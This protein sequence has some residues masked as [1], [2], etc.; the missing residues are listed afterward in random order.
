MHMRTI[1]VVSSAL[2][3]GLAAEVCAQSQ[4]SAP[5]PPTAPATSSTGTT[6]QFGLNLARIQRG[7]KKSAERQDFDGLNLRYYVNVYAPAPSI[8]LFTREDNLSSG[9]A[10]Y[11]GPTHNEMMQVMTPQEFRA[12]AADFTG[13]ARWLANKTKK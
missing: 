5:S 4:D 12:P 11:G 13:I 8:R 2:M 6:E 10:P 7:L 3:L 1:S 9:M